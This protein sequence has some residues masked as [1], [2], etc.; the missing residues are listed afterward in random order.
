MPQDLS[1]LIFGKLMVV[2]PWIHKR[3]VNRNIWQCLCE[4][5]NTKRLVTSELISGKIK[6]C[7]CRW[8]KHGHMRNNV[9]SPEYMAWIDLKRRCADTTNMR[10]G[11]RGISVCDRWLNGE[12][13]KHPF[14]CFLED[15]GPRPEGDYSID[16]YP[17]NDGNYEPNNCRWATRKEQANNRSNNV[18]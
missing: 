11:G 17:D 10:Y 15:M 9:S 13:G 18:A 4:C 5:G 1:G 12:N 14:L 7:G 2:G 8:T 16:R 6:S 3:S